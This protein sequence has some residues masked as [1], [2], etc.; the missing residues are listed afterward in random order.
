VYNQAMFDEAAHQCIQ[1]ICK[2][3]RI[4]LESIRPLSGGQVNQ[5]FLLNDQVVLRI[6]SR[7]DAF[8]RLRCETELLQ[9][10]VGLVPVAAVLAFGQQ[11]GQVYQ[12]QEYVR[13]EKL[14]LIWD[15]LSPGTQDRLVAEFA[16]IRQALATLRFADFGRVSQPALRHHTW[17]TYIC[18][19]FEQTLAE[20]NER[21]IHLVPGFVQLARDYFD[22]YRH[23]LSSGVSTL[24]HGDLWLGNILVDQGRIAALI[25]FEFALHAP[26]DYELHILEDFCL[27]PNDYAEEDPSVDR[28]F[29][30]VDFAGFFRRLR[31]VDP[32]LFD[33]PHLRE[34]V[35]LYH[36]QST[37]HSY[38]EWRKQQSAVIPYHQ[39]AAQGFYMAR[40]SNYT[41]NHS[42]R[43]F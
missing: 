2:R 15:Q 39:P 7:E 36:L 30:T 32:I 24:V 29:T 8:E 20:I 38:L 40:I 34:R 25:D 16:G 22:Q 41:S 5:V 4:S 14:Y 42:V 28:T 26:P 18:T 19:L 10:L 33:M 21:Q 37:F 27:Y 35:N 6:G 11:D 9:Q 12:L 1:A 43:M 31:R 3:E 17:E 13:G 23:T